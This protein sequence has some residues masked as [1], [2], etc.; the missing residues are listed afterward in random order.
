MSICRICGCRK[1]KYVTLEASHPRENECGKK[2]E[3]FFCRNCGCLQEISF[4]EDYSEIY[5]PNYFV[6]GNGIKEWLWNKYAQYSITH[7]G[8]LGRI[9]SLIYKPFDYSFTSMVGKDEPI[10]D[11]GCATGGYLRQLYN[12][13]YSNLTGVDPY[14]PEGVK[15]DQITFVK[16]DLFAF[17]ERKT[18]YKL[19]TLINVFEHLEDPKRVLECLRKMVLKDGY[20]VILLPL[21]NPYLWKR[22]GTSIWNLSPPE[23]LYIHTIDSMRLL[24]KECGFW[25][26]DYYTECSSILWSDKKNMDANRVRQNSSRGLISSIGCALLSRKNRKKI[27]KSK[28]GNQAVFIF[29]PE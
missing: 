23:H 2:Y 8:T 28:L 29:R 9:I 17:S 15:S 13:G 20:V 3:Y 11:V 21:I 16:E 26:Y 25:V 24:A 19:I 18:K 12:N 6:N 22:F 1:V 10:L 7:K 14:M 4:P 5:S 27:D